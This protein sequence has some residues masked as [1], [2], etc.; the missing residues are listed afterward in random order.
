MPRQFLFTNSEDQAYTRLGMGS[1]WQDAM[2]E[3]IASFATKAA[4]ALAR[5][6]AAELEYILA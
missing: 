2:F 1:A 5:K 4:P 6:R 3:W